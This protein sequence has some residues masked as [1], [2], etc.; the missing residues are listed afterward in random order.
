MS[1]EYQLLESTLKKKICS[2]DSEHFDGIRNSI[3]N[4]VEKPIAEIIQ[5]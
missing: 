4:S 3:T 1:N 2:F 5:Y